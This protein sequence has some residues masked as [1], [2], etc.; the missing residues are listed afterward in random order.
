MA[1]G[2]VF[3]RIVRLQVLSFENTLHDVGVVASMFFKFHLFH[4]LT[5]IFLRRPFPLAQHLNSN[6]CVLQVTAAPEGTV[7]GLSTDYLRAADAAER[8]QQNLD[9]DHALLRRFTAGVL[10]QACSPVVPQVRTLQAGRITLEKEG[11]HIM[12]HMAPVTLQRCHVAV[13]GVRRP[14]SRS[15]WAGR[16]RHSHLV[17]AQQCALYRR[18][19]RRCSPRARC[20][21]PSPARW[22]RSAWRLTVCTLLQVWTPL[23]YAR[24]LCSAFPWTLDP[25][26]VANSLAAAEGEPDAEAVLAG[27]VAPA[28]APGPPRGDPA[29]YPAAYLAGNGAL[30]LGSRD[31]SKLGGGNP[32]LASPGVPHSPASHSSG[33]W[34]SGRS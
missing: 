25:L 16:T 5:H 9:K 33:G 14:R 34:G 11:A 6:I 15:R 7:A 29:A 30:G 12:P 10:H 31:L 32:G 22:P 23:Q 1:L 24:A 26:S 4:S 13:A 27:C 28:L 19:A 8:L 17:G 20:A 21:A 18:C 2:V 3:L